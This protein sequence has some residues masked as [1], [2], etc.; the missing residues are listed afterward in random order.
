[1]LRS[2]IFALVVFPHL[3]HACSCGGLVTS[4]NRTW[5]SG[6][7]IFLGKTTSLEKLANREGGPPDSY[8]VHFTVEPPNPPHPHP[9]SLVRR[10]ALEER[11]EVHLGGVGIY[12]FY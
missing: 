5:N 4:C 3:V 7:T 10:R 9:F 11:V 1:M 2:I 12:F 6:E 8:A